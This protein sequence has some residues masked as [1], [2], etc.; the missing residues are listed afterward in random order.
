MGLIDITPTILHLTWLN[1][2]VGDA[3][4]MKRL[5]RLLISDFFLQEKI[6]CRQWVAQGGNSSHLPIIPALF[7]E[8]PKPQMNY[9][10]TKDNSYNAAIREIWIPIMTNLL[11]QWLQ[12]LNNLKR[13][14]K[15]SIAWSKEK[16]LRE[17]R[18]LSEIVN[19]MRNLYNSEGFEFLS[20]HSKQEL[21]SLEAKKKD[22]PDQ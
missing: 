15:A 21:Q 22:L 1:N 14:K 11:T 13:A 2:H 6:K 18:L 19:K 17:E 9:K 8:E 20:A 7:S 12:F 5:D 4:V 10:W 3:R 16:R